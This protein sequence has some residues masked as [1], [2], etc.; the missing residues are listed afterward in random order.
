MSCTSEHGGEDDA[1]VGAAAS[2]QTHSR[3][4]GSQKSDRVVYGQD[5]ACDSESLAE[6]KPN[7]NWSNL[8]RHIAR[9][10]ARDILDTD[11]K[12]G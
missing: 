1:D 9:A 6:P 3:K 8:I 12:E 10:I 11:A 2:P 7:E 5:E 4:S